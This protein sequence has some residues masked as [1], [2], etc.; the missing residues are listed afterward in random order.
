MKKMIKVSK[1][2]RWSSIF[3]HVPLFTG[4]R[5]VFLVHLYHRVNHVDYSNYH[6]Q[7]TFSLSTSDCKAQ[8][9]LTIK[10]FSCLDVTAE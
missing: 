5:H 3:E 8:S 4:K 7:N 6:V 9:V 2:I 10:I 1:F